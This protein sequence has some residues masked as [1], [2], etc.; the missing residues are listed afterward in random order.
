MFLSRLEMFVS[1]R[2]MA[3]GCPVLVMPAMYVVAEG[4][5]NKAACQFFAFTLKP[6]EYSASGWNVMSWSFLWIYNC[7]DGWMLELWAGFCDNL[8]FVLWCCHG[9][10]SWLYMKGFFVSWMLFLCGFNGVGFLCLWSDQ[11]C[12]A[13]DHGRVILV[14]VFGSCVLV[15]WY[16]LAFG[17]SVFLWSG[18]GAASWCWW[19][20]GGHLIDRVERCGLSVFIV[21]E[22]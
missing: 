2:W 8:F 22:L 3:A 13:A 10:G 1:L 4:P 14:Q 16:L 7:R 19:A 6:G 11:W 9:F 15:V 21:C 20:G 17:G 5:W 12:F 18:G